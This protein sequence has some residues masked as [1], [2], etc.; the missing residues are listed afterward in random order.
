MPHMRKKLLLLF[1]LAIPAIGCGE[2]IDDIN[3]RMPLY[4]RVKRYNIRETEFSKTTTRKIK[5]HTAANYSDED[6]QNL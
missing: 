3:D 5:R 2:T 6:S 4:K 1:A